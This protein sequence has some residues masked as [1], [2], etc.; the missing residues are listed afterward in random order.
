MTED[1]HTR[2]VAGALFECIGHDLA[3]TTELDVAVGVDLAAGD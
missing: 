3:D 1:G 2:V